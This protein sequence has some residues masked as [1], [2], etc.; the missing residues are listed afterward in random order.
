MRAIQI[1]EFGGSDK[2]LEKDIPIPTPEEN[3]VVVKLEYSGINYMDVYMRN[4]SYAKS[5][6]YQ[7][8]LPMTVG[9]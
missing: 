5:H 1:D 7:T 2:L 4:G 3:E 8:P 6:T 9:M